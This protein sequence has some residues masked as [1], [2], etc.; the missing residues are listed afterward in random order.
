MEA[1][2]LN[3]PVIYCMIYRMVIITI[4]DFLE[5]RKN[6][7]ASAIEVMD[8]SPTEDNHVEGKAISVKREATE[9]NGDMVKRQKV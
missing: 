9:E 8:E 2:S 5:L 7:V 6:I 1:K 3:I 4:H